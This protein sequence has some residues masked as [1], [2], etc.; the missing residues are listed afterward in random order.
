[1]KIFPYI[2]CIM[3]RPKTKKI[4]II[5]NGLL[6]VDC[7]GL[8]FEF[9]DKIFGIVLILIK[10]FA[11]VLPTTEFN[12]V[13]FNMAFVKVVILGLLLNSF[14]VFCCCLRILFFIRN[15]KSI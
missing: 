15:K 12:G 8:L 9:V 3:F 4:A 7:V 5:I 1:M 10:L 11:C 2:N 6:S 14:E 13:V